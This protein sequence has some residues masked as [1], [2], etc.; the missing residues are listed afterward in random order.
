MR[1]T[2]EKNHALQEALMVCKAKVQ[3]VER[4]KQPEVKS[5]EECEKKI[6]NLSKWL[7]G[8]DNRQRS[9]QMT[10]RGS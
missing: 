4:E 5:K 9:P 2:E 10:C 1:V 8:K 7:N 6:R 3:K